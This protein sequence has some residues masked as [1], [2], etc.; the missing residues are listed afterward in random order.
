MTQGQFIDAD[1]CPLPV[2]TAVTRRRADHR[3]HQRNDQHR[4]T[5]LSIIKHIRGRIRPVRLV[6]ALLP[7]VELGVPRFAELST[8]AAELR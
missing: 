8:G 3:Q 5:I 4:S 6:T 1:D 7:P 2:T